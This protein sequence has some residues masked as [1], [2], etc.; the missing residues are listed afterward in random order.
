G[1]GTITNDDG[2][3]ALSINDQTVTEG[4]AGTV[5]AV[6]TVTLSFASGQTVTV[7][8]ATANGTASAGSDYTGVS[9]TLTFGP[10]ST[11]QNITVPITGDLVNEPN[12]TFFVNL[13]GPVNATISDNQG[14][15]TILDDDAPPSLS[16]DDATVS[17]GNAGTVNAVF[18]V[19]LSSASASTVTVN[20]ATLDGTATAGTDYAATSGTLI[21][22]PG[23]TIQNITVAINGDSVNEPD[24][25]F[26][27][28][29][30]GPANAGISDG[31][32]LG[33]IVNDDAAP[34]LSISDATVVEGNSGT[35][36]AVFAVTLSSASASQ[37]TV[38]YATASGTATAGTDYVAVSGTLTFPPGSTIQNIT[39]PVNGDTVL[40]P[41]ETFT[42]NLSSPV[43]ATIANG[44][45][46]GTITND[47]RSTLSISDASV[48]EGS[49]G[50]VFTI[51]LSSP[52]TS[53]VTV[54][55]A[56]ADGSALA[57]SDY[58]AASGTLTFAPGTTAQNVTIA[59]I[60]D[61]LSEGT[62]TFA[63]NLSNPVNAAI[64]DGLGIGTIIDDDLGG[65]LQFS[66][67]TYT[68][69]EG[70]GSATITVTRTGGNAG[71]VQVTYA[72]S[73][74]T[75]TAGADYTATSGTI[76]FAADETSKTFTV[77]VIDDALFEGNETVNLALSNPTGGANL[78][79][80]NTAVLTITDNDPAPSGS[81][82]FS[83][84]AYSVTESVGSALIT[85]ARTGSTDAAVS[86]NYATSNGTATAGAD[87]TSASG[88]L[89]FAAGQ[90]SASFT[91]PILD[92]LLVEGNET[93][94]LVLSGPSAGASLGTPAAAILTI[95]NDDNPAP[96]LSG[97]TPITGDPAG[98]TFVRISGRYFTPGMTVQFGG[99]LAANI[100]L[101]DENAL[102]CTTPPGAGTVDVSVT[103]ANGSASLPRAF[104]YVAAP[105][106]T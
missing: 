51:T 58:V 95:L 32:G 57:G 90:T 28:N 82:Q 55:F 71:G 84:A 91:V 36:N 72:A 8:Y 4:N 63:V 17:E 92:D 80:P 13:T 97:L 12:E 64:A 85:V 104:T 11:I 29:L 73:N 61:S 93:V 44:V 70:A 47:D 86:V 87:Y 60:G 42:V 16:I 14:V 37:V 25:T 24:E 96:I 27:V 56:T 31:Q 103:T 105:A 53:V 75:A 15:G 52:S 69:G 77:P 74:G 78:G 59:V 99:V 19:T 46:T 38:N 39:V 65:T 20:F 88:T 2:M 83:S 18:T 33:T 3:P 54:D 7:N 45:G 10:G 66:S 21:F 48:S 67:A 79:T 22:P 94:N 81:L 89:S 100:Q 98:G 6:F 1:L 106:G 41:D 101:A 43:N 102:T 68:V 30:S 5:N 40:E 76:L 23:S 34:R 35:V 26:F 50:A 62:E 9:G 49:G